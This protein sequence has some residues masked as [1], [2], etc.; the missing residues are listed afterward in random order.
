M[1]GVPTIGTGSPNRMMPLIRIIT[2]VPLDRLWDDGGDLAAQREGYLSRVSLLDMLRQYPVEF[3]VA[4]FGW[5]LRRVDVAN[6]YD[7]R[8]SES[9]ENLVNAPE[10]GFRIE[11]FPGKFAYVASEWA[12][13]IQTP[14]VLL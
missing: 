6:C 12:G 7:F 8:K 2:H 9:A 10:V 3:Y 13:E 4:D 1:P 14:I 5:P 11:D